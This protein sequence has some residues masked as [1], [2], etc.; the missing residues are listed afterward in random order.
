M[1]TKLLQAKIKKDHGSRVARG[2]RKSGLI[3]TVLYGHKQEILML[4][5]DGK[6]FNKTFDSGAKMVNLKWEDSEEMALIKDVQYDTFG[7]EILHVDFVRID[8]TERITTRV[9]VV[10]HGDSPGARE[11]GVLS[12]FMKEVEIECL[13]MEI[14][15]N[16]RISISDLNIGNAIHI[17]D[18]EFAP[19][20]KVLENQDTIV[21]SVH[22]AAEE[23]EISE[24]ELVAEPEVITARKPE[25]GKEAE[26]KD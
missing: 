14:P 4:L 1:E 9:P 13:P 22:F 16:I 17:K 10:L 3:P 15:E 12:H 6:E 2:Y 20:V 19:N 7:R 8:L 18:V 21:V 24:E 5:I 26:N 11:G 23:K 25:E